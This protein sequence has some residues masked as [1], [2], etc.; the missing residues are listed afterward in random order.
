MATVASGTATC[1][2]G[3]TNCGTI[4]AGSRTEVVLYNDTTTFNT[5]A[6]VSDTTYNVYFWLDN[7]TLSNND[8][9]AGASFAGFIHAEATQAD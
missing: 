7:D 5:D 3:V 9:N 4:P 6:S 1:G 2:S 8:A